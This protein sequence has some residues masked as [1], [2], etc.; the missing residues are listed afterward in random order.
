PGREII[1]T[2]TLVFDNSSEAVRSNLENAKI[3]YHEQVVCSTR[4]YI[5][6]GNCIEVM[7][8]RGANDL[9]E[10]ISNTILGIKGIK[11]GHLTTTTTG[12][13]I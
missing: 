9:I 4:A 2:L 13:F 5:D 1:G 7:I 8:L 10:Q 11:H 6:E 3:Q 12:K